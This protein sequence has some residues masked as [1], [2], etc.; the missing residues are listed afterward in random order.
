M[1]ATVVPID[2]AGEGIAHAG[3]G[4]VDAYAGDKVKL[5]GLARRPRIR[6][7]SRCSAE[8][9]SFEP[10]AMALPRNDSA[11]RLEVNRAL[12]QVYLSGEI[13]TIFD[14]WLGK[15]GTPDGPAR[16]DVPALRDPA[17]IGKMRCAS[18]RTP[19]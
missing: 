8:D 19:T 13:E 9:L 7:S 11:L 14:Q 1:N 16:R 2:D 6:P 3:V 5:V 15:L 10:Y 18:A 4:R 17:V 12:T